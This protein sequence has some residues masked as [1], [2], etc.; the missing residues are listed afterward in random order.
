MFAL[1]L[2]LL[3]AGASLHTKSPVEKVV[4]L[5]EELKAKVEADGANEQKT[6]DK[7]ACWCEKTTQRKADAIDDGKKLI[8][9][10][11]TT[12]LT[13]KGA[14]AVLESEIA[15]HEAEI[16]K[17]NE[18]MKKLTGIREQENADYQEQKDYQETAIGSLHTAIQVLSGAGTGGDKATTYG[19][20]KIASSVR[21]AVLDSPHLASLSE[22]K[23][24]VLKNFL[25]DPAKFGFVQTEP[26]DYYDKKAQAKASYSP[27]SATVTG[28][29]KDMYDT[30]A[31][32]IEKTNQEESNAQKGFEDVIDEK[33]AKVKMLQ[34]AV[35]EKTATK[36]TKSQEL[37]DAEELLEA[38]QK[39]V[40]DDKEIFEMARQSCKEKSDE[41][42]ERGRMRTEELSGINK[43]IEILTSDDARSTFISASGTR[44]QDTFGSAGVDV[45]FLQVSEESTPRGKAYAALKKSIDATK[46]LR[47]VRLAVAVRT[48]AKGHFD[49]VIAEIDTMVATLAAEEKGDIEQRDW[50]I[51]TRDT[52][53]NDSED[54][55]WEIDQ[56]QNKMD[57]AEMKKKKLQKRKA[58]TEAAKEQLLDD[59]AQATSDRAEENANYI[60]AKDDDVKAAGLLEDAIAAISSYGAN[61][62]SFLQK[63]PVFEVSADQAPDAS[64]SGGDKHKG[65][66]TGIISL[67]T[68]IKENLENEVV[69]ADKAEEKAIAEFDAL[70]KASAAQDEAYATQIT[71]LDTSIAETDSEINAD[72][73][74]QTDTQTQ[75]NDVDTYRADVKA[76]SCEWIQDTFTKRAEARKK[77]H[78][79]LEQAKS[80]LAGAEGGDFGFLQRVRVQ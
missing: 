34:S 62:P 51:E 40:A 66:T 37:A 28:I 48:A 55:Q 73:G 2:P 74:S 63:Q 5:M 30:F 32:D 14:I 33:T 65:A 75:K 42:D 16:A 47:L 49:D 11:T 13:L 10:T 78:D 77:E 31:A 35:T 53:K 26:S 68:Q 29:L 67:M 19:L 15:E 21:T 24:K 36:A 18:E 23:S 39:Q 38:T 52:E 44:P 7:F 27:Q 46:S 59:M 12:I 69:L 76:N 56:L 60:A 4:E 22:E 54:L 61:N 57:R 71:G 79:G 58:E 70:T 20:L 64:F 41:W 1:F 6:Y 45:D 9:T 80:I 8:G 17:N 50:C 25:E 72:K 3:A 43:A